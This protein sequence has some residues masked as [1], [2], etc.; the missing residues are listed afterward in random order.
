MRT[1]GGCRCLR[2]LP[3]HRQRDIRRFFLN[4]RAENQRMRERVAELEAEL[5]RR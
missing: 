4:L 2:E 5:R 3:G 1:N